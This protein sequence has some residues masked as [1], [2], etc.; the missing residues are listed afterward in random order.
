MFH[1]AGPIPVACSR[2]SAAWWNTGTASAPAAKPSRMRLKSMK[3]P[4][5]AA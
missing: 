5:A 1:A 2:A 4:S 3:P